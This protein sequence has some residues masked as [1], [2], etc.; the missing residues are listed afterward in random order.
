MGEAGIE[1]ENSRGMNYGVC[2]FLLL[3][4]IL[5]Y[6]FFTGCSYSY[7]EKG[8][9]EALV[10]ETFTGLAYPIEND[11]TNVW[12]ANITIRNY[13]DRHLELH[14]IENKYDIACEECPKD[15]NVKADILYNFKTFP[16]TG[17]IDYFLNA[18]RILIGFGIAF[19]PYPRLRSSV[20]FNSKHF[21]VG[22]FASFGFANVSYSV[23]QVNYMEQGNMAGASSTWV[24]SLYCDDCSEWKYNGNFGAYINI[25][26]TK[27]I[28]LSYALSAFSPW[29]YD[30]IKCYEGGIQDCSLTFD[31]PYIFAQYFGVSYL[32]TKHIQ[33]SLGA[34][35]YFGNAF[36]E[37]LWNLESKTSFMF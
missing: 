24:D 32:F 11:S 37:R 8:S 36:S 35:I 31:F 34:K 1:K 4:S 17:S 2:K 7:I 13:S 30:D 3:I 21:E 20:G 27:K 5:L 16:I 19:D 29:L 12:K 25:F 33:F 10:P 15:Q 28:S 22:G 14:G 6:L 23:N 9:F 26:P 18:K